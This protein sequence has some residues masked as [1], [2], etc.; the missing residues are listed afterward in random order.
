MVLQFVSKKV[1]FE[2]FKWNL[3]KS[4]N[5][6]SKEANSPRI[7]WLFSTMSHEK[8][9]L[10]KESIHNSLSIRDF[11][12]SANV[13]KTYRMLHEEKFFFFDKSNKFQLPLRQTSENSFHKQIMKWKQNFFYCN[14]V[15]FNWN[16]FFFLL[17]NSEHSKT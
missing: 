16:Q 7:C 11:I 4:K 5:W 17:F 14:A 2:I 12:F 1:I 8:D 10:N 13:K 15:D 9:N 6:F 3:E